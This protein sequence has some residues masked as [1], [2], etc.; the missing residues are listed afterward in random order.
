MT[1]TASYVAP[2]PVDLIFSVATGLKFV[3]STFEIPKSLVTA[4]GIFVLG[5]TSS[6][7]TDRKSF[8]CPACTCSPALTCSGDASSHG[9]IG[10]SSGILLALC[11]LGLAAGAFGVHTSRRPQTA[12]GREFLQAESKQP[13]QPTL[14]DLVDTPVTRTRLSSTPSG[15]KK[16]GNGTKS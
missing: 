9:G 6:W 15:L 11:L 7:F 10:F 3:M 2:F 12:P 5:W 8:E 4:G 16:L 14:Q 1:G 13:P